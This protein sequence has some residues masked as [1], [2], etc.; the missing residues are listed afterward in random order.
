MKRVSLVLIIII[1]LL[2]LSVTVQKLSFNSSGPGLIASEALAAKKKLKAG[3]IDPKTGKKI[4]YW[5]APMD[6]TYIRDEPGKSPMGMD[7]CR[8]TKKRAAKRNQVQRSA[9][10]R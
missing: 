2:G 9:S 4:K 5:V 8:S 6:P 1:G 10:I 7:L 3:M